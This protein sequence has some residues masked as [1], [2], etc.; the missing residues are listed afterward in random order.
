MI[1][2]LIVRPKKET[3][4]QKARRLPKQETLDAYDLTEVGKL[5]DHL[6]QGEKTSLL[7]AATSKSFAFGEGG[8]QM[9]NLLAKGMGQGLIDTGI[10]LLKRMNPFSKEKVN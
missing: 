9:M 7:K 3:P 10:S 6:A 8:K 4:N 2:P 5:Y 1:Q